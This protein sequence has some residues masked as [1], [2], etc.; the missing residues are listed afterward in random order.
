MQKHGKARE[1]EGGVP[2]R[3]CEAGPS[4]RENTPAR[5]R[6]RSGEDKHRQCLRSDAPEGVVDEHK[7]GVRVQP[8]SCSGALR[9]KTM[10]DL[11][12]AQLG[13]RLRERFR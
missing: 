4:R 13:K 6:A 5:L 8:F 12:R 10:R 11:M 1:K 2:G 3:D 9:A 7:E